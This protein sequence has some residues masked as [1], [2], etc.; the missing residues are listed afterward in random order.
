MK[1]RILSGI[2]FVTYSIQP[3]VWAQAESPA[4]PSNPRYAL[5]HIQGELSPLTEQGYKVIALSHGSLEPGLGETLILEKLPEGT[6]SPTYQIAVPN[7]ILPDVLEDELNRLG[8]NGYRVVLNGAFSHSKVEKGWWLLDFLLQPSTGYERR[9][10]IM[11]YRHVLMERTLTKCRYLVPRTNFRL[12]DKKAKR[13]FAEGHRLVGATYDGELFLIMEQCGDTIHGTANPGTQ[14]PA[15]DTRMRYRVIKTADGEKAQ[16]QLDQAASQGYRVLLSD[17]GMLA[18]EK[19][20][21][22][23][24]PRE[25][26]VVSVPDS[27]TLEQALNS[28]KGFCMVANTMSVTQK[29]KRKSRRIF[30]VLEKSPDHKT[31]CQY[32]ALSVRDHNLPSLQDEVNVAAEQGYRVMGVTDD[33]TATIVIMERPI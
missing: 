10:Y 21:P 23:A 1:F 12:T 9:T 7:Q 19:A 31:G 2:L 16:K 33:S 17:W 8:F 18:M 11:N 29:D 15:D 32:R 20:T 25:Y 30:V 6:L 26:H 27:P 28:S 24:G 14:Q 3:S 13:A 5:I 22:G 4:A